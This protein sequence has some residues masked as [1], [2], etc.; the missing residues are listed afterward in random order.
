[1]RLIDDE[2][3]RVSQN[4]DNMLV[5]DSLR[6]SIEKLM[7]SDE[8]TPDLVPVAVVQ[9]DTTRIQLD[10]LRVEQTSKGW[11]LVGVAPISEGKKIVQAERNSWKD[12][13]ILESHIV[14]IW[15]RDLSRGELRV[16]VDFQSEV[17]T[18][19]ITL[20]FTEMSVQTRVL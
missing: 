20:G 17:G 10:L 15:K 14:E 1:M 2:W 13:A 11:T 18:C 8:S 4:P 3:S 7:V 16:D 19:T 5:S 12:A 6:D 9:S